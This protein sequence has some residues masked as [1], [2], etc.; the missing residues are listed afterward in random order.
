MTSEISELEKA[1]KLLAG[2]L[3]KIKASL[4]IFKI[5]GLNSAIINSS[6]IAGKE[7]LAFAQTFSF[8]AILFRLHNVFE[9]QGGKYQRCSIHGVFSLAKKHPVRYSIY[10]NDFVSKYGNTPSGDWKHD[11]RGVVS[12]QIKIMEKTLEQIN[13][14]RNQRL[15]HLELVDIGK[16]YHIHYDALEKLLNFASDFCLFIHGNLLGLILPPV[17]EHSACENSLVGLLKYIGVSNPVRHF[18]VPKELQSNL[19][20]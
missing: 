15:G 11:V 18:S 1:N 3:V 7:F 14:L 10:E 16:L 9:Q 5:I 19:E 8:D 17:S 6:V 20:K 13:N 2:E 12:R 4:D